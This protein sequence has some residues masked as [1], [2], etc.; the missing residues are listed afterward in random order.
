VAGNSSAHKS[1]ARG[2]V[3]RN[4][5]A[6]I[7]VSAAKHSATE[8]SEG[9]ST[10]R[11]M[12]KKSAANL[13]STVKSVG[14][15]KSQASI[16][17]KSPEVVVGQTVKLDE[18]EKRMSSL[19]QHQSAGPLPPAESVVKVKKGAPFINNSELNLQGSLLNESSKN[20]TFKASPANLSPDSGADFK[21][22]RL[23]Q[24]GSKVLR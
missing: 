19:A 22:H 12:A 21:A 16:A 9:S 6:H 4:S 18:T 3:A 15:K 2:S 1:A 20:V 7:S 11:S 24:R 13:S 5:A 8:R 14:E 10:K 17:E 23:L